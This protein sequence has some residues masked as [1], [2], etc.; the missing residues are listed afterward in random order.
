MVLTGAGATLYPVLRD[1]FNAFETSL[2]QLVSAAPRRRVLISATNAFMAHWLAPRVADFNKLHPGID[3]DL[4][5]SDQPVELVADQAD[6]AIRYGRGPYQG[7]HGEVLFSDHFAPLASP[8]LG[9]ADPSD[10]RFALISFRWMREHP[11]NPTWTAWFE[12][13]GMSTAARSGQLRFS[14]EGHA[15]QAAL[16]GQGIALLS[17]DLLAAELRAG[18]LVQLPGPVLP[19]HTY[20]VVSSSGHAPEP[21][22]AAARAWLCAQGSDAA[23]GSNR[24]V[25]DD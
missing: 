16:A 19:G 4:H 7:M 2:R 21:H 10:E 25:Q 24:V 13:A 20:H 15:I 12:A 11:G 6:L 23:V 22:V 8:A 18:R 5:A 14:D 3:L 9:A 17:V 1:G